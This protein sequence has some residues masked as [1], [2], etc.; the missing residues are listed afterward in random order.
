LKKAE[1]IVIMLDSAGL[2][3]LEYDMRNQRYRIPIT[4]DKLQKREHLL[5]EILGKAY[6]EFN[7]NASTD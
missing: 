2:D 6:R 5:V 4:K 7:G 1:E 3:I